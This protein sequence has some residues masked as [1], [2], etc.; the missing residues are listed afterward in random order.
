VTSVARP[1]AEE[2]WF[3]PGAAG[4]EKR[5]GMQGS[6]MWTLWFGGKEGDKPEINKL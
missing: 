3:E 1:R 4:T 5:I 2:Q 6:Y